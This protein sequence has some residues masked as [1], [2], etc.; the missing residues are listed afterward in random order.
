MSVC[1]SF[2]SVYVNERESLTVRIGGLFWRKLRTNLSALICCEFVAA[3]RAF[4]ALFS[5]LA[6]VSLSSLCLSLLSDL[7]SPFVR[8]CRPPAESLMFVSTFV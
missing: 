1:M 8:P 2:A 3:V 7:H 6:S 5:F 4:F